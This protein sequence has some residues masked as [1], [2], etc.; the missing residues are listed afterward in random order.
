MTTIALIMTIATIITK[1]TTIT[2]TKT[3]ITKIKTK[4]IK[5]TISNTVFLIAKRRTQLELKIKS[6]ALIFLSNRKVLFPIG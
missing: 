1:I 6:L 4:T 2:T 3:T 5:I